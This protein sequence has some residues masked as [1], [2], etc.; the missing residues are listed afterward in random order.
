MLVYIHTVCGLVEITVGIFVMKHG[1]Y[2][3]PMVICLGNVSW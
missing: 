2:I 3:K 1:D